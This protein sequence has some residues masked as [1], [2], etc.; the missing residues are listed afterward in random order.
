LQVAKNPDCA[1]QDNHALT[2]RVQGQK[3]ISM[4]QRTEEP[5]T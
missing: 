3:L 5:A 4:F 2:I 1:I